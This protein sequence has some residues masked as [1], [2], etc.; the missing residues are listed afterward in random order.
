METAGTL[1]RFFGLKGKT[2]LVTGAGGGLG[3][4]LA[5]GLAGAGASVALADLPGSAGLREVHARLEQGATQ[6]RPWRPTCP[7]WLVRRRWST[8]SSTP[9]ARSTF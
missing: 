2:A 8:K 6:C 3:S 4:A 5:E 7:T 1:E 9:T